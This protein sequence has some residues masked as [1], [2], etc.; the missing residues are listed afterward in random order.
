[1]DD[2]HIQA[3]TLLSDRVSNL[4]EILT[5]LYDRK[6]RKELTAAGAL[7]H[8][9]LRFP[10]PIC[11]WPGS[12]PITEDPITLDPMRQERVMP[13][14]VFSST[15][16]LCDASWHCFSCCG[17]PA[18]FTSEEI[19]RCAPFE[20]AACVK[21]E[22]AQI[23]SPFTLVCQEAMARRVKLLVP[24]YPATVKDAQILINEEGDPALQLH[25]QTAQKVD[26]VMRLAVTM[27]QEAGGQCST[28][29]QVNIHHRKPVSSA[30]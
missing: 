3:F 27:Y 23:T 14:E 12:E 19:E 20:V 4:E 8:D 2:P 25:L 1:M 5:A 17:D 24:K 30:W 18:V 16:T 29:R 21:C 6:R 9:L 28:I 7:D 11:R 22:E 10:F 26:D 13:G 15:F